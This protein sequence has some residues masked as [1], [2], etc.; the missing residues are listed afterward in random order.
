MESD[1]GKNKIYPTA[2]IISP[3]FYHGAYDCSF[4]FW[5]NMWNQNMALKSDVRLNVY[6]RKYGK[7]TLLF[8]TRQLT[9][10]QWKEQ[11]VT[12]PHCPNDFSVSFPNNCLLIVSLTAKATRWPRSTRKLNVLKVFVRISNLRGSSF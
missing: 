3:W 5:Y 10:S 6:Y 11:K 7:D 2:Q 4:T 1:K 9:G 12:L 8:R